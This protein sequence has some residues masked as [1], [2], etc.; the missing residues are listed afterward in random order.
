MFPD[1]SYVPD[2]TRDMRFGLQSY[3]LSFSAW[4]MF[5]NLVDYE[6][7]EL[8]PA[9]LAVTNMTV[10]SKVA[11]NTARIT[12]T[13]S[14]LG[15]QDASA[16]ATRFRVGSISLGT[17]ATPAVSAGESVTVSV[18][19]NTKG[20][21]KTYTLTAAADWWQS[22]AEPSETNNLGTLRVSVRNNVVTV[23][24]FTPGAF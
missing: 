2:E 10:Q 14:N 18:L 13:I 15:E 9:D 16:S 19:W 21:S 11:K 7:P 4:Q 17:P 8:A 24:S 3:A 6:R 5:L 12:A 23:I 22:L 20:L 1:P